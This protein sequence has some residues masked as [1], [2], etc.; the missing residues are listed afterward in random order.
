MEEKWKDIPLLSKYQISSLGR[1]KSKQ[2]ITKCNKGFINRKE[3]LMTP[4]SRGKKGYEYEC[5]RLKTDVGDTKT[6][7]I[8][9]LVAD[10]FIPN[11][12]KKT[13]C[14]PY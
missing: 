3:R 13:N 6:Y 8:H 2:R 10:A 5:I 12:E 11:P 1:V 7:S 14:R 4:Q 9:R